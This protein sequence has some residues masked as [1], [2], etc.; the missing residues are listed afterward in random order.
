M[1]R[2][3]RPQSTSH[4][5]VTS[6]APLRATLQ[7]LSVLFFVFFVF[8]PYCTFCLCV[9]L[10]EIEVQPQHHGKVEQI[11]GDASKDRP[12]S[13]TTSTSASATPPASP[14]ARPPAA[15]FARHALCSRSPPG[16]G[17]NG[18]HLPV[19]VHLCSSLPYFWVYS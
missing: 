2:F 18:R 8:C 3:K 19:R 7:N 11:R 4:L 17:Q 16:G 9:Y 12:T 14:P 1:K 13:R 5:S 10:L 6:S 15:I